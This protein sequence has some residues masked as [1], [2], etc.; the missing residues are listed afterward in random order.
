MDIEVVSTWAASSA[1]GGCRGR[2]EVAF[3]DLAEMSLERAPHGPLM[4]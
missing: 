2:A 3:A 4:A 1:L